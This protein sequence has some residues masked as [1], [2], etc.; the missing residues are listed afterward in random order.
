MEN[1]KKTN[2]ARVGGMRFPALQF[3]IDHAIWNKADR[4]QDTKTNPAIGTK[5]VLNVLANSMRLL[6]NKMVP[7]RTI[8]LRVQ[9]QK[10]M[11]HSCTTSGSLFAQSGGGRERAASK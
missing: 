4:A 2:A 8:E 7:E 11:P 9:I 6:A 5:K 10:S 1:P 3:G